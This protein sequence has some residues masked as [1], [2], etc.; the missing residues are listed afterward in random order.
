MIIPAFVASGSPNFILDNE[1]FAV[2]KLIPT[3]A[4]DS[5]INSFASP[6][7]VTDPAELS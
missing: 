7:A 5:S 6:A 3:L 2:K 4:P 1:S